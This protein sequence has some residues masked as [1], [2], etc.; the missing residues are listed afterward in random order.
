MSYRPDDSTPVIG[1]SADGRHRAYVLT[2]FM[3]PDS[4]VY[5]DLL[6]DVPVTVTFCDLDNRVQVFT[7]PSRGRPLDV[8]VGGSDSC[9]PRKMLLGV[10]SARTRYW[11]DT[12]LPLDDDA[13]SPFPYART[14]SVRTT[15]GEWRQAHP[16]TDV[17]VGKLPFTPT[18]P[19]FRYAPSPE[20]KD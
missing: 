17:Y 20:G 16:D 6:G 18:D 15:W 5:N 13:A 11:Q 10:K 4:H 8:T 14:E 2:A 19:T 7:A 1:V 12:G 3:R 9:R